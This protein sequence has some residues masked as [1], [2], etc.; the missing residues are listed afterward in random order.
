M[1]RI[2]TLLSTRLRVHHYDWPHG[3]GRAPHWAALW[4]AQGT[5]AYHR[6]GLGTLPAWVQI[7]N[8]INRRSSDL[9]PQIVYRFFRKYDLQSPGICAFLLLVVPAVG[10]RALIEGPSSNPNLLIRTYAIFYT[11]LISSVVFYRLS[12]FHPLARYP[13]P[14]LAKVSNL[15]F[16][17]IRGTAFKCSRLIP[18]LPKAH[19]GWQGRQ[20][21]HYMNLHKKYGDA[22][23]VGT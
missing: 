17:S 22:V 20:H 7:T 9:P 23:R 2:P 5:S 18:Y 16:V 15:W 12:P 4:E 3:C 14:V 21:V 6:I 8:S 11:T 10:S 1:W 13:G 19:L